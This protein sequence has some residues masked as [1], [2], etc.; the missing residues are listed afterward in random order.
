[1]VG[2]LVWTLKA[3]VQFASLW[4]MVIQD[5]RIVRFHYPRRYFLS[6]F[7]CMD[8]SSSVVSLATVNCSLVLAFL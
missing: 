4:R 1:L 2:I 5:P 3:M 6:G 8:Q 7:L